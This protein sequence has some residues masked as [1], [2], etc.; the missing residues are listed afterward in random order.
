MNSLIF[1]F[2]RSNSKFI[3]YLRYI[4]VVGKTAL[5]SY[6]SK[7]TGLKPAIKAGTLAFW[8][9]QKGTGKM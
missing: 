2:Y 3:G 7:L 1:Q 5:S 9:A 6:G 4:S 8:F